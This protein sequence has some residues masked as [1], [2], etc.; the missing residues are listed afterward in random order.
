MKQIF[1]TK[2]GSPEV[3]QFQ[4]VSKPIPKDNEILV[5]VYTASVTAGDIILR[6]MKLP[7]MNKVVKFLA[8]LA[9]GYK[10][11]RK[12]FL[13]TEFAGEIESV[14]C[15]VTRF[16]T[17]DQVFG[18]TTGLKIGAYAEYICVP[19][20]WKQGVVEKKP[21]NLSYEQAVAIPVGAMTALYLLKKAKNQKNQKV[22]IYGAS[23]SV[24]SYAVQLANYFE[25]IVTGVCSSFNLNLVKSLSAV[26]VLDYTKNEVKENN[27]KYDIVFDAVGK[28]SPA[29]SKRLLKPTGQFVSV[30]NYTSESSES[31]IFLRTLIESNKIRLIID[32]QYFFDDIVE[33]HQYVEMG[34]KKG[35]VIIQINPQNSK[36][37]EI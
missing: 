25:S 16:K 10:K 31:L 35:N 6:S 36:Q 12:A 22:L 37:K 32:R 29:L 9:L 4:E 33:A 1:Y 14:G 26:K 21:N 19:E 34:H 13:G 20:Q 30:K 18:T 17:G 23:G 11:P 8:R 24:G 5:K 15:K 28:L 2:Y 7:E 27:E 3:L